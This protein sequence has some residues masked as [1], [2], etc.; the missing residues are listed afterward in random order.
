[1]RKEVLSALCTPPVSRGGMPPV[2]LALL[3]FVVKNLALIF[4]A[5]FR[6][7]R[8]LRVG[9]RTAQLVATSRRQVLQRALG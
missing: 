8:E 5:R 3:F 1:M 2:I 9:N 6:L 4:W 7:R